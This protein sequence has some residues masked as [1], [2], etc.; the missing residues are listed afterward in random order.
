MEK[1]NTNLKFCI[2]RLVYSTVPN[3]RWN[4]GEAGGLT[5]RWGVGNLK[6][7]SQGGVEEILFDTLIC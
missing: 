7:N 6:F 5:G 1:V 3:R 4:G 2:I